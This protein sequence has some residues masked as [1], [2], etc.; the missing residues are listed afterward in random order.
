M[1][2]SIL[3]SASKQINVIKRKSGEK[4]IE[5]IY[6]EDAM[7]I[8]YG[9]PAGAA[10][11]SKFLTNKWISN[12][13]GAYNDSGASKHKIEEFVNSMGIDVTESEKDISEYHSFNDFF[14]RK[15]HS[16][17]RPINRLTNSIISP[18]DGRLLV[19]PNITDATISN[20]KWAPIKLID[21]FQ[22]NESLSERYKNGACAILR[23]CPSDYHRFHFPVSGKAGITKTVPGLLHSVNPYALEQQIPVYCMNKRTLCELDSDQFGKVLLIEVGALFVGTIVQTYRPA[24]Q[25]EKGDEKGYFKFGGS[26]CIFFFENDIMEFDDDIVKASQQGIETLVQMGEKIGHLAERKA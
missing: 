3:G 7:K 10:F 24:V 6:G 16:R 8:F 22:G 23:L 9:S 21:L 20:V 26:T 13:Y 11:T 12:I 25:V 19:F 14:A 4:F 18:G 2:K 17:A 15:L 5:K 1:L